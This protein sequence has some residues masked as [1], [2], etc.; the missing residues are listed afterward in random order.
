MKILIASTPAIG[1]VNPMLAIARVLMTDHEVAI[2]TGSGFR[3]RVEASGA[4]FFPLPLDADFEP[5][6]PFAQIPEL[7]ALLPG[8]N[9]CASPWSAFSSTKFRLNMRVCKGVQVSLRRPNSVR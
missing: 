5:T 3:T 6:D 2:Y 9:R 7:K 8:S 1:H 4:E